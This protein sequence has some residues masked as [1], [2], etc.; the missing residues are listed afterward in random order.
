M[1]FSRILSVSLY[2]NYRNT[3]GYRDGLEQQLVDAYELK[4]YIEELERTNK[5][6]I[7]LLENR[8][9]DVNKLEID[10]SKL[11]NKVNE[12]KKVVPFG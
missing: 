6:L 7:G 12:S 11:R 8:Q 10:N 5:R 2:D 9:K 1:S 4:V 3:G